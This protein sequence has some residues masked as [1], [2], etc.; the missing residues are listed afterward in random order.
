M[1][2]GLTTMTGKIVASVAVLGS[3]AAVA[4]L[5]TF[6]TFTSSTSAST[7]VSTGIVQ[8]A[9]GAAGTAANRLTVGASGLVP[10]DTM[11][12]A[13]ELSNTGNQNLASVVLTTNATTSSVLD[14]DVT[15]GLKLKVESCPTAWVET[16]TVPAGGYT[17]T[18]AGGATTLLNNVPI[19]QTTTT[20][21]G[22]NS[23]TAGGVDRL[24]VTLSL[25]S[26]ADNSFQNKNS[27]INFTFLGTQRNGVSK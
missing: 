6:G 16:P 9:L 5:G 23:L 2:L 27:T 8:I 1:K 19:I 22:L 20:L 13:V 12:R 17:Y 18:C 25:P 10:T 11:E 15:N 3:A 7:T 4:G 24:R 21:T 26:T 14:T